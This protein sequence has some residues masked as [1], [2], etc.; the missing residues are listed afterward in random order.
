MLVQLF[1]D[2]IETAR[3]IVGVVNHETAGAIR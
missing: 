3:Q 1:S 2:F